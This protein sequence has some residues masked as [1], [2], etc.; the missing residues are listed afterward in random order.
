VLAHGRQSVPHYRGHLLNPGHKISGPAIIVLEDTT[1][2][3]G[4]ADNATIDAYSN[5]LIDVGLDHG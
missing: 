5:I 2:Y 1:V 4:I 3:L